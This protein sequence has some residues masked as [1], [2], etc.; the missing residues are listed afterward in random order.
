MLKRMTAAL[1][2]LT[3]LA[4][5]VRAESAKPDYDATI[6]GDSAE[7]VKIK[8][9]ANKPADQSSARA[10]VESYNRV[11]GFFIDLF[12]MEEH[13]A[14]KE[15]AEAIGQKVERAVCGKLI[16][17]AC[18]D[19]MYTLQ[20]K[21]DTERKEKEAAEIKDGMKPRR[22]LPAKVTGEKTEGDQTLLEVEEY[23][24]ST[25]KNREG[26]W[27]SSTHIEQ[28]RFFCVAKDG[29]WH[30]DRIEKYKADYNAK[31]DKDGKSPM[32]WKTDDVLTD[33]LR[34]FSRP[35]PKVT[36]PAAGTPETLARAAITWLNVARRTSMDKLAQSLYGQI[37][38][39]FKPL[40]SARNLKDAAAAAETAEVEAAKRAEQE[41]KERAERKISVKEVEGG[42]Q[43]TIAPRDRW[44][45]EILLTIVKTDQGL[46][47][48]K[49]ALR[50]METKYDDKGNKTETEKI[51]PLNS[52]SQLE[53]N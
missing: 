32:I 9:V 36:E 42:W 15:K 6:E 48:S 24:E 3:L 2:I 38:D 39:L 4:L 43:A 30:I 33:M 13:R 49:A 11:R 34:F 8:I 50:R 28:S 20:K 41:A 40:F 35:L 17:D 7:N 45:A 47:I 52:P 29:V 5:G 26:K 27:E 25:M 53:W 21:R 51:E 44:S 31:P 19:E 37:L 16:T 23:F 1:A 18:L 46:R 22:R 14:F 12:F 10:T